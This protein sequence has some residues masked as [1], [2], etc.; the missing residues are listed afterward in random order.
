MLLRNMKLYILGTIT[1]MQVLYFGNDGFD[2]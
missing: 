2:A 1:V